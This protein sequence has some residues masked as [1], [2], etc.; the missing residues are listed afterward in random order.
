MLVV[1]PRAQ[2]ISQRSPSFL[3]SAGHQRCT[4]WH[5]SHI[6]GLGRLCIFSAHA[7]PACTLAGYGVATLH[8]SCHKQCDKARA[9]LFLSLQMKVVLSNTPALVAKASVATCHA[10]C[11]MSAQRGTQ[12][13]WGQL[14]KVASCSAAVCGLK[15]RE[16]TGATC[17][18]NH[19]NDYSVTQC[20]PQALAYRWHT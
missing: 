13:R 9:S 2:R 3:C 1:A 7:H 16:S 14:P 6:A 19:C 8:V 5:K 4:E 15:P 20:V 12:L 10:A 17:G 18:H 11:R